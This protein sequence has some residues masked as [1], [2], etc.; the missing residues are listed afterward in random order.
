MLIDY[1]SFHKLHVKG[2]LRSCRL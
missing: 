1:I 2:H